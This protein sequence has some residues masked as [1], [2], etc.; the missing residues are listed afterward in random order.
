MS[1]KCLNFQMLPKLCHGDRNHDDIMELQEDINT[2]IEWANK[3][4]SM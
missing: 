2:L 1:A 3:R 4:V